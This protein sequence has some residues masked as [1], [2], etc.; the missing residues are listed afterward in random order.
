MWR[1]RPGSQEQLDQSLYCLTFILIYM[2]NLELPSMFKCLVYYSKCLDIRMT[3]IFTIILC[4]LSAIWTYRNDPK[5]LDSLP[6]H[7]HF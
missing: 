3:M 4:K 5:F 2:L 1:P 6:F 7:L